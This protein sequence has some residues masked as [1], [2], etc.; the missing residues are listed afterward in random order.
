M[1]FG[2]FLLPG[3]RLRAPQFARQLLDRRLCKWDKC[4]YRY[5]TMEA[6]IAHHLLHLGFDITDR[7]T[8]R[9]VLNDI[10]TLLNPPRETAVSGQVAGVLTD[11]E[12]AA[13]DIE[14]EEGKEDEGE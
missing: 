6:A 10:R 4:H 14:L 1:D 3:G 13:I 11:E 8:Q 7:R 2:Q 9:A 5:T 12:I